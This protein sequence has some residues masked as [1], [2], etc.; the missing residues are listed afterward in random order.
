MVWLKCCPPRKTNHLLTGFRTF[1][2]RQ[3]MNSWPAG[4]RIAFVGKLGVMSR[5][6][7]F[8]IV[9]EHGGLPIDRGT[10]SVD[11]IVV[12][13]D[14]D[15][16]SLRID[17]ESSNVEVLQETEFWRR[18]GLEHSHQTDAQLYT[19]RML[20]ELIAV[21]LRSVRR[22]TRMQLLLP[23][24]CLHRLNY[25]DFEGL[26]NARQLKLWSESGLSTDSIVRQLQGL[27]RIIG[28][29]QTSTKVEPS[30]L[31]RCNIFCE[32]QTLLLRHENRWVDAQGQWR[33]DFDQTA[34]AD[35]SELEDSP[36][37]T[38]SIAAF[39]NVQDEH[40]QQNGQIDQAELLRLAEQAE[41]DGELAE[42]VQWFRVLMTRFG[43]QPE[44]H[45]ALAELLYR[46]GET[47]AARERY[48]AALEMDENFV[49]ARANLGCVLLET[50]QIEMGIAALQ[51]VLQQNEDFAD[52]HY[53]LARSL[54][55]LERFADA[56][57][58]WQRFMELAPNSPWAAEAI[59]RL[60]A[61]N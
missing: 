52:V 39:R 22:W 24:R 37:A 50:G 9:R 20:A 17:S 48:Y 13:A 6:A 42:A 19:P 10:T 40:G 28:E 4:L 46:L 11:V 53:H 45:F 41:D 38:I 43:P 44:I 21:P 54:E 14:S 27:L 30:V 49:E 34:N 8:A 25:Y 35:A 2:N 32:G 33:I 29:L 5:Q 12:G 51:G 3:I 56:I 1:P 36:A 57:V 60:Q 23:V 18:L 31:D 47:G 61:P 55:D 7:A 59:E 58:H 16:S 26:Q 15:S